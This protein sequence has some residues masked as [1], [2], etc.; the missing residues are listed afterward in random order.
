MKQKKSIFLKEDAKRLKWPELAA[1][2][3]VPFVIYAC[4]LPQPTE[5]TIKPPLAMDVEQVRDTLTGRLYYTQ[6]QA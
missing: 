5:T 6:V 3:V 1:I 4:A 2:C